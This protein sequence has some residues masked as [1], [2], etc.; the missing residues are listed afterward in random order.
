VREADSSVAP[1][2]HPL[3]LAVRGRIRDNSESGA[4]GAIVRLI[5]RGM[6]KGKSCHWHWHCVCQ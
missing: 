2:T 1:R 5:N 4:T 3:A 6:K